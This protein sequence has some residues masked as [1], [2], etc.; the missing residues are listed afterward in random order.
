MIGKHRVNQFFAFGVMA[1]LDLKPPLHLSRR[2]AYLSAA[3]WC[4]ASALSA[5][6]L[7]PRAYVISPLHSNAFTLTYSFYKGDIL[8]DGAL[9]V[10]NATGSISIPTFTYYHSFDFLGR[11]ANIVA[12]LPYGVGDFHGNVVAST[13]TYAY[14]SGL[15]DSVFRFAINLKGGPAMNVEEFRKWTEKTVIGVSL[16]VIVPTGQYDSSRPL[17]WGTNRGSFKPE[18]GYSRRWGHWVLDGYGAVW[19]FTQN[20]TFFTFPP[21]A[22]QTQT[23]K[24]ILACETHLSYDVKP[25]LWVSLDGNFW[26]GG[27]TTVGGVQNAHTLQSN[28]RIGLTLSAPF[29]KHQSL[30]LSYNAGAYINYGG[31]YHNVSL[32]WQYSW[33]GRPN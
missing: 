2:I 20:N 9:P 26:Y 13:K 12:S 14:R 31:D 18:V 24:P 11:S 25:R 33:I 8:L 1:C 23:E 17:N 3:S 21:P 32:A 28:S 5:Q 19:L 7:A 16:K 6:D 10:N 22:E 15:M 30:K 29:T 27:R 4:L